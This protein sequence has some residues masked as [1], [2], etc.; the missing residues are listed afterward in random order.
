MGLDDRALRCGAHPPL[1]AGA[2]ARLGTGPGP[3]HNNCS[4]KHA[5][6]LA[7]A[8]RLGEEAGAYLDPGSATQRRI[9]EVVAAVCGTDPGGVLRATDGCSAPTFAVP[10][11]AA[12]R[13]F[14]LLAR[15]QDAPADLRGALERIA[16]AMNAHPWWV[17]GTGRFDTDLMR[18][19]GVRLV[20]KAGAE[21]VQGIADRETGLGLFL[22]VEDGGGRAAAPAA[23]AVLRALGWLSPDAAGGLA[24]HAAPV[25]TNHAG[26]PVGHI[27]AFVPPGD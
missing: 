1:H 24:P 12:A 16:G 25:L 6:M 11:R 4:G 9:L 26:L 8:L 2:A 22:K 5:G 15:P 7:L 23:M 20:S 13:A 3:V 10:L 21:A 27:E 18:A 19:G 14:A 17:A